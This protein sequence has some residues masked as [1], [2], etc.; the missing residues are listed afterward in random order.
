MNDHILNLTTAEKQDSF[1]I[2]NYQIR[3]CQKCRLYNTRRQALPGE[4]DV[5]STV[6]FVALSP[7][8]KEDVQNRMFVGPSGRVFNKLL[9]A[10]GIDRDKI[11]MTNLV[12][13]MLPQNRK[14]KMDEIEACSTFLDEELLIIRPEVIVPLGYYAARA[15]LSKYH[16]GYSLLQKD[17]IKINFGEILTLNG[18]KIYP[19]PHPASLLYNPAYEASTVEKYKRLKVFME[20]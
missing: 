10:A 7:G 17:T 14:P 19:L 12:K 6:M 15:V 11:F 1:R 20:A 16:A 9:K 4:G 8:A 5:D 3:A 2:L 13:C 18:R